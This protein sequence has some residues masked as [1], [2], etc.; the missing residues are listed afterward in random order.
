MTI[1]DLKRFDK[2]LRQIQD[3]YGTGFE[4]L[5]KLWLDYAKDNGMTVYQVGSQYA[6]WKGRK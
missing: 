2:R 1:N 6:A 4:I 3:P 5:R